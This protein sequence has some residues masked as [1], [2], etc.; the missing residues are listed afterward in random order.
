MAIIID[1]LCNNSLQTCSVLSLESLVEK[2]TV[3]L[4]KYSWST[5]NEKNQEKL[6]FGYLKKKKKL[7]IVTYF[8]FFFLFNEI[9]LTWE[10]SDL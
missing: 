4:C 1:I 2:K 9:N 6:V 10:E 3:D 8:F 7:Y 5:K